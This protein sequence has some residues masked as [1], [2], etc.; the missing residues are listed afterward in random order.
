MAEERPPFRKPL[1]LGC[2]FMSGTGTRTEK[3]PLGIA[4]A[5]LVHASRRIPAGDPPPLAPNAELDFIGK[6][7]PRIGARAMVTGAARYTV[8]VRLPGMLFARVLRSPHAHAR[9][10]SIDTSAA[11]RH[12]EVRAVYVV[13]ENRRAASRIPSFGTAGTLPTLRYVGASVA[14]IAAATRSAAD[15][16]IRLIKVNYEVLPFVVDMDE[17]RQPGAPKVFE[18]A[19][20]VGGSAAA[21]TAEAVNVFGPTTDSFFGGPRG[22]VRQGFSQADVVVEGQFRTQV[23]THCCLETHAIVADWQ[24]EGLTVYISIQDTVGVGNDLAVAFGIARERVRVVTEFMGGGFGSK[25]SVGDYG[26]IAVELSR[27]AGAPVALAFDRSEEQQIGGNRPGTWQQLRIGARRDGTLTAISLLSYGTAGVELGAGVGNIAQAMYD[28]P[29]FEMA[30][31]DVLMHAAPGCPMRAPGNVQGAFALEQLLDELADQ[32]G[33]DPLALRDRIDPSAVRREERR[34]GAERFGWGQRQPAGADSGPVKRGVGVAQAFWPGIV[35]TN[36]ACEVRLAR[37]GLIELRS[38]VQDIGSG[39]RTLLAQVVAEELGVRPEDVSIR[40]GDTNFPPGP[41]SG[42]SK[43]AGSITPAARKAAYQ[44]RRKLFATA[45]PALGAKPE[46]LA[47]RQGRIFL[48]SNPSRGI[49]F[50]Q[51]AGLLDEEGVSAVAERGDNYG[52]FRVISSMN[53]ARE[54]LGGV[55]FAEVA[56]DTETGI[57]RVHRITAVHDCGRPMN[58]RQ[59]ESQ[60]HGGIIMGISFALFESRLLDRDTGR[61]V[62]ADLEQYKLAGSHETPAIEVIVLE[63]YQAIS[64]TDACGIAEPATI[65]TAAAVANAVYNATGVRMHDLPMTPGA[66]LAALGRL[67]GRN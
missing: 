11:E 52:G 47:V 16:A 51:A 44:V 50:G 46:D 36:A 64:A 18:S 20:D 34:I 28:C 12:P 6:S 1:V 38:S 24:P 41:S 54:D 15:E 53:I 9:V 42:G 60:I 37:D 33:L 17:A 62:N 13:T 59:I 26:Y 66:V 4:G 29:N 61:M 32:L 31:H 57:V 7:I 56:V 39:I 22:D 65:A 27:K 30:Q 58:P 10:L 25:L 2:L 14:A 55:Q 40:I 21:G 67:P 23:Q 45:A 8:D 3:F 19:G 35:Q 49:T 5:S 63:N 48:R 43:T